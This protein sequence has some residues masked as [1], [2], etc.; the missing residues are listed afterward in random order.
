[1]N[2]NEYSPATN[3]IGQAKS[4]VAKEWPW[5]ERPR[6]LKAMQADMGDVLWTKGYR[7][8]PLTLAADQ[9]RVLFHDGEK[10]VCLNRKNGEQMW[11]SKPLS[12]RS[13]IATNF[14][15]T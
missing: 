5:D 14:G 4:R 10:I 15:P 6:R 12:K 1:M 9:Q 3:N 7:V 13:P 8:V 11:A 2:Y